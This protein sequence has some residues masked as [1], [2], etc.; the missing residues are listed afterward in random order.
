MNNNSNNRKN[1]NFS[2]TYSAKNC[3]KCNNCYKCKSSATFQDQSENNKN[4]SKQTQKC[5][6][7][8]YN[9]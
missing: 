5:H 9:I 2:K 8:K 3:S 6:L 4:I 7:Y 1:Q